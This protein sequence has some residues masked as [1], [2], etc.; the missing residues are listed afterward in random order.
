MAP[1]GS[2]VR[3]N[4]AQTMTNIN[5]VR[6]FSLSR[7]RP[8]IRPWFIVPIERLCNF[9]DLFNAFLNWRTN[10]KLKRSSRTQGINLNITLCKTNTVSRKDKTWLSLVFSNRYVFFIVVW[11]LTSATIRCSIYD[12]MQSVVDI[13]ATVITPN[14]AR[15]GVETYRE[16]AFQLRNT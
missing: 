11:L 7:R 9:L 10:R 8:R 4:N 1:C 5:V 14:N 6:R 15:S 16:S 13:T 12:G 3:R 2:S